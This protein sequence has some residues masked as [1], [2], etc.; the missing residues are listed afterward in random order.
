MRG[1]K[2][3]LRDLAK[4]IYVDIESL[5]DELKENRQTLRDLERRGLEG[6]EFYVTV[7]E[8]HPRGTDLR[9]VGFS[10]CAGTNLAETVRRAEV[11]FV[12]KQRGRG[13]D[14]PLEHVD[15]AVSVEL[16]GKSVYIPGRFWE[17]YTAAE[18]KKRVRG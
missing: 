17:K 4:G 18:R 3:L 6:K 9:G 15:Y 1:S 13:A 11:G 14:Y 16:A 5:K 8:R 12:T 10:T 7:Y 2:Q